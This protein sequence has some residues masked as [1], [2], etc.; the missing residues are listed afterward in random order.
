[1]SKPMNQ[2]AIDIFR[3]AGVEAIAKLCREFP[4]LHAAIK[5][6]E[7]LGLPFDV[8]LMIA[9][10]GITK[11]MLKR[12]EMDKSIAVILDDIVKMATTGETVTETV[13]K[14]FP[15]GSRTVQ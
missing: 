15:N 6:G 7:D 1:M 11:A 2:E 4:P 12:Q 9:V 3:Q 10:T 13:S 8:C 14:G 5:V